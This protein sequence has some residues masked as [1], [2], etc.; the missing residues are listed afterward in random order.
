MGSDASIFYELHNMA[1]TGAAHGELTF[2]HVAGGV[3]H[4]GDVHVIK[5]AQ[6]YQLLFAAHE[7]QFALVSHFQPLLHLDEFFGGHGEWD[8]LP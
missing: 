6:A 7:L 5:L 1:V 8:D 2:T 3:A 4:N